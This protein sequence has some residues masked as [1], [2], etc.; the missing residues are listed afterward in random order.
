MPDPVAGLCPLWFGLVGW[1]LLSLI[2]RLIKRESTVVGER[3]CGWVEH[4]SLTV[5][6]AGSPAGELAHCWVL[7]GHLLWVC[8]WCHLLAWPV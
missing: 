1:G 5:R 6:R 7:R 8:S 3:G 4:M 2:P